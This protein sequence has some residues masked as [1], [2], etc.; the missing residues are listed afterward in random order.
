MES[1]DNAYLTALRAGRAGATAAQGA[2]SDSAVIKGGVSVT[3]GSSAQDSRYHS[4]RTQGTTINAGE[5]VSINARGDIAGQ[6]VQIGAKQ[7]CWMR[8]G[9]S[10]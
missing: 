1:G 3:L 2:L 7:G 6:G 4:T 8:D 10:C 9:I 5:K